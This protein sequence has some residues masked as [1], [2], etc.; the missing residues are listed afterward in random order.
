M[1]SKIIDGI[2][3]QL[4]N[5][6]GDGCTIYTED[7]KQ[8]LKE[9][10]F[11]ITH[12]SSQSSELLSDRYRREN[13]FDILYFPKRSNDHAE[14]ECIAELMY[15]GM[16]HITL[17][18]GTIRNGTGMRHETVDGLLHFFVNYNTITKRREAKSEVM[19]ELISNITLKKEDI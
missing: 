4:N 10:C 17:T 5:I 1:L 11:L 3:I 8:S 18:D 16:N 14:M 19:G 2:A 6:F 9:P 12:I 15:A 13:T 7:V